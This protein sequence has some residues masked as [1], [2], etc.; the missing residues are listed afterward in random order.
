M[1]GHLAGL[2][3]QLEVGQAVE[4]GGVDACAF[5]GE[6]Q[7]VGIGKTCCKLFQRGRRELMKDADSMPAQ[8]AE[9]IERTDYILVVVGNDNTH[10]GLTRSV[11]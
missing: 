10:V 4:Q 6:Y 2:A 1:A 8:L 11:Q 5:A 7:G 9:A 3:D